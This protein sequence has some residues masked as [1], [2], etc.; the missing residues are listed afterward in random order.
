MTW[1]SITATGPISIG[2]LTPIGQNSG[3]VG[4]R[5]PPNGHHLA[6]CLNLPPDCQ[7]WGPFWYFSR[8]LYLVLPQTVY[9]TDVNHTDENTLP[10]NFYCLQWRD[11]QWKVR[12]E[13][14]DQEIEI[15]GGR[16]LI[17]ANILKSFWQS[18]KRE[19]LNPD[20]HP[21]KNLPWQ[22]LTLSHN[23]REDFQVKDEGGFFAEMTT[24]MDVGWAIAIKIIGDYQPPQ[25]SYLGAGGV[26]VVITPL[27]SSWDWLGDS[28]TEE[29]TGGILLT[30]ALWQ[31][32]KQ[33]MSVPTP[34]LPLKAYAADVGQPWQS[35]K[36]VKHRH[37]QNQ[38]ISVLTPGEW[39][40]PAGAV[41]LWE[42]NC[43]LSHSGPINDV[44]NRH[45]LGYGHLW[46]F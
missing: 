17:N 43:P 7:I 31:R 37:Q 26:P 40:T 35:W 5:F 28:V 19:N 9:T 24:L 33:K 16:Y 45:V 38:L 3:Q 41:Y 27:T 32:G 46:L 12:L 30:G 22:T 29:V 15:I 1:Y 20:N 10:N 25:W 42:G 4:C 39:L 23:S 6:G 14:E 44:Y 13:H 8:S 34:N 2:N 18:G 36:K 21:L 11:S